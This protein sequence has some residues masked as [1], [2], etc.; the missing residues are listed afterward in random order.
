[1][2]L[3]SETNENETKR[4]GLSQ[5]YQSKRVF[6]ACSVTRLADLL[7]F[8]QLFKACGNNYFAQIAHIFREVKGVKILHFSSEIFLGN[9]YRYLATFNWSRNCTN[10]YR[11]HQQDFEE[12]IRLKKMQSHHF[13]R[14]ILMA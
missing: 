4:Q 9:F 14:Q 13:G 2:A 12:A 8:G 3:N 5:I 7:H 6:F 11:N 10:Q 1:M